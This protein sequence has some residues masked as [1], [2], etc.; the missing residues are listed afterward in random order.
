MFMRFSVTLGAAGVFLV[1]STGHA[2]T[3]RIMTSEEL[4]QAPYIVCE[5]SDNDGGVGY[6]APR[7]ENDPKGIE[8]FHY[9]HKKLELELGRTLYSDCSQHT[10]LGEVYGRKFTVGQ[11]WV[12]GADRRITVRP[13]PG[14]PENWSKIPVPGEKAPEPDEGDLKTLTLLYQ[15]G[16]P[17]T[18]GYGFASIQ[19]KYRFI[20]CD[21]EV[22]AAYSLDPDSVQTG[23]TYM[24]AE[25]AVPV[26]D[27]AAPKPASIGFSATAKPDLT[28]SS[29]MN[30]NIR[31][32]YG[33][34]S[35]GYAGPALG[36][37]CFTGQTQSVGKVADIVQGKHE[38]AELNAILQDSLVLV[39]AISGMN[40]LDHP[41]RNS[42]LDGAARAA[43]AKAEEDRLAAEQAAAAE[44]K[45]KWEEVN[46]RFEAQQAA[47][48]AA[49]EARRAEE[50]KY[51][52]D[53]AA[54]EAADA[55]YARE[56]AAH[57]AA[58]TKAA[59]E[60]AEYERKMA[61]YRAAGGGD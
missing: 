61:E 42:R 58:L 24:S 26:G 5:S 51:R 29:L 22:H 6:A 28:S 41:L 56:V 39:H 49:R 16:T 23:D 45:R 54:K 36:Y 8:R 7:N 13:F 33:S 31:Q 12:D 25:G 55:K 11:T 46:A 10:K 40:A 44:E 35:D 19:V 47:A 2:Q 43:I 4:D 20:A 21:G 59:E 60:R 38:P 15:T 32:Q 3:A 9:Y 34:F 1:T 48:E 37:G 30:L 14:I 53:L 17:Q 50:D 52:R 27:V 18:P 57:E